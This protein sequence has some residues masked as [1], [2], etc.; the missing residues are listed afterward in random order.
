MP[1]YND[2]NHP[3][4]YVVSNIPKGEKVLLL[5]YSVKDDKAVLGYKEITIGENKTENITLNNLSKARFKGAVSE[6]LSY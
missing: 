2:S 6:L 5:A 4:Q 3:D 1:V